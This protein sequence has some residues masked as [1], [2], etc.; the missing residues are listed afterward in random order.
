MDKN[1]NKHH[2]IIEHVFLVKF[3]SNKMEEIRLDN[4]RREQ[5]DFNNTNGIKR[6]KKS[7]KHRA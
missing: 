3:I 1:K 6:Q 7:N 2:G 4:A 5:F